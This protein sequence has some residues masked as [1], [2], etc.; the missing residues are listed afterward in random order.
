MSTYNGHKNWTHWNVA[1][2]LF[3]DYGLYQLVSR[4]LRCYTKDR[5]AKRLLEE[6]NDMGLTETPDGAK[7]SYTA[8]RAAM[9]GE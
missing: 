4:Y 7:Y 1:L 9:V 5:A 6:L 3:N 2:W 8:I